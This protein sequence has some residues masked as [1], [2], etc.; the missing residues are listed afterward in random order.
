MDHPLPYSWNLVA[1]TNVKMIEKLEKSISILKEVLDKNPTRS[2]I[3]KALFQEKKPRKYSMSAEQ[4][5]TKNTDHQA[6]KNTNV[7]T[8]HDLYREVETQDK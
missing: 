2:Y 3:Q 1:D 6:K 5:L 4:Y 7:I 8:F